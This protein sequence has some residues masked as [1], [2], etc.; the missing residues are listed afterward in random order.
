MAWDVE[1]HVVYVAILPMQDFVAFT[2][3]NWYTAEKEEAKSSCRDDPVP[4]T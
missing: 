1:G 3:W 4:A 2:G